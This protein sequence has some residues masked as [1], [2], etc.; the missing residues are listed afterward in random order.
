M[1]ITDIKYH[2]VEVPFGNK[3]RPA[4]FPGA[5]EETQSVFVVRVYTDEGIVG[6]ASAEAPFG[7][8]P[9][10]AAMV[11]Y[12]KP[13][14][15]GENP[16][17]IERLIWKLRHTARVVARP[18]LVENALWDIIGKACGQ[19]VYKIFG[20]CRERVKVYAAWGEL[21]PIER[22]AEDAASLLEEGFRAVKLRLHHDTLPED[23][24]LVE[25]VRDVVGD[26]MEIMVDANQGTALER[27]GVVW[28]YQRAL[29][30]ARALEDLGVVWLEEPLYRYDFENL[31]RLSNQ[32][33]IAIAGGE[34]NRGLSEFWSLL[35][36]DSYDIIQP[37][38]TMSEGMSQIRKIAAM[39]EARGKLC[40]PHGWIP[41]VG[42]VATFHLA[43]AIPNLS[44]V[45][46]PYDPPSLAPNVFQGI[47]KTPVL[48]EPDGYISLP[49][50]PGFGV[51]LDDDVI[52]KYEVAL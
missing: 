48:I 32:V 39:W 29:Q 5:V 27:P 8:A 31:S 6:L 51:E 24:A 9:V 30:T 37:N 36:G 47:L 12:L 23:I 21:R 35:L 34:L 22:R 19:P 46:Y 43:S 2:Y 28:S 18:W 40:N 11:N 16:F 14:I 38:C 25:M 49:Q 44:Y 45:E 52:Q 20:G 15:I 10:L 13:A 26:R 7:L 50:G 4:W 42:L 1:Q 3:F 41:G 33:D 17:Y